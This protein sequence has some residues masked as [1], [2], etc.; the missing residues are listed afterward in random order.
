MIRTRI[1]KN[2]LI[3][4]W[5][6]KYPRCWMNSHVLMVLF[7]IH[8]KR[9]RIVQSLSS[10]MQKQIGLNEVHRWVFFF[11]AQ[12]VCTNSNPFVWCWSFNVDRN[13]Y[14][15]FG[16]L[17]KKQKGCQH[18]PRMKQM[19]VK[20][21]KSGRFTVHFLFSRVEKGFFFIGICVWLSASK[22]TQRVWRFKCYLVWWLDGRKKRD[23]DRY[24]VSEHLLL[25]FFF[26][27]HSRIVLFA[28]F[29]FL[30]FCKDLLDRR[31]NSKTS[32]SLNTQI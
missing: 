11:C 24:Q 9:T 25:T 21:H 4:I 19:R 5:I 8:V 29:V 30:V 22:S 16:K 7:W 18:V 31:Y 1:W 15:A 20:I 28:C 12:R 10:R 26:I 6:W 14:Q 17:S 32:S 13:F 2:S 23:S 27:A 3:R